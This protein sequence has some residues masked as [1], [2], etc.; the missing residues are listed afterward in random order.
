MWRLGEHALSRV[1]GGI[2]ANGDGVAEFGPA[3]LSGGES[4]AQKFVGQSVADAVLAVP[5]DPDLDIYSRKTPEGFRILMGHL[6]DGLYPVDDMIAFL[7][8]PQPLADTL[9]SRGKY[10]H[11]SLVLLFDEEAGRIVYGGP[12]QVGLISGTSFALPFICGG[13]SPGLG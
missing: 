11:S 2:D 8:L 6:P 9:R 13:P 10:I 3:V 7:Q 1:S 12:D 4:I 5:T